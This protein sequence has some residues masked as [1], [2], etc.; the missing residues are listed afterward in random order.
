MG[1][2][3]TMVVRVMVAAGTST[4]PDVLLDDVL[5]GRGDRGVFDDQPL[6]TT[7][8]GWLWRWRRRLRMLLLRVVDHAERVGG[9]HQPQSQGPTQQEHDSL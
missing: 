6:G 5:R 1:L 8:A 3:T 9:F 4:V 2:T 7:E